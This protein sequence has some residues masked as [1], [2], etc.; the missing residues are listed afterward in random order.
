MPLEAQ[1]T[2]C[3]VIAYG[4]GGVLDTV[5]EGE[6]GVLFGEQSAAAVRDAIAKFETMQFNAGALRTQAEYFSRSMFGERI[7]RFVEDRWNEFHRA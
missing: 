6:T 4:A 7:K 2:G 1:A 5:R 3:P